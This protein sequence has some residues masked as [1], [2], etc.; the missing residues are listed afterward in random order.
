M[1]FRMAMTVVLAWLAA[2]S[3]AE[4][5][6]RQ[7]PEEQKKQRERLTAELR[8]LTF[9]MQMARAHVEAARADNVASLQ[10]LGLLTDR[11]E[12][13][14]R[15]KIIGADELAMLQMTRDRYHQES[16]QKK[17]AVGARLFQ[18][19]LLVWEYRGVDAALKKLTAKEK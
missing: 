9:Q 10:I 7:Q 12:L 3:V 15:S 17:A 6:P 5:R 18:V 1:K 14:R 8:S 2:V 4:A 19:M 11:L 16:V 13:Y